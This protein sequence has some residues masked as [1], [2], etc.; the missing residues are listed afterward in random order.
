[1]ELLPGA[2]GGS[3]T[4]PVKFSIDQVLARG[5]DPDR[6]QARSTIVNVCCGGRVSSQ[7]KVQAAPA[8]AD[9]ITM[10]VPTAW[11]TCST[12]LPEDRRR[13]DRNQSWKRPGCTHLLRQLRRLRYQGPAGGH[14]IP[15][16]HHIAI[17]INALR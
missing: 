6:W 5:E 15:L 2:A 3:D 4:F 17:A 7:W 11:A 9:F 1:M 8:L 14:L 16:A 13:R 10:K 12:F